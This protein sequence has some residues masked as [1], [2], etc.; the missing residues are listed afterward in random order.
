MYYIQHSHQSVYRGVSCVSILL[1]TGGPLDMR[2]LLMLLLKKIW[3]EMKE[4]MLEYLRWTLEFLSWKSNM[5]FQLQPRNSEAREPT[6]NYYLFPQLSNSV[7]QTQKN[8][9]CLRMNS[10]LQINSSSIYRFLCFILF[11][12]RSQPYN[13]ELGIIISQIFSC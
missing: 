1:N 10:Y 7:F 12:T 5:G 8:Y 11:V 6:T 2:I 13:F 4:P 3:A 9:N